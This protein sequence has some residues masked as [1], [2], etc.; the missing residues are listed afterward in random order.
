VYLGEWHTH[1][2]AD[3]TPSSIDRAD[4]KLRL[5][6]DR[7]DADFVFFLIVGLE[8][9]AVWEGSRSSHEIVRLA[10]RHAASIQAT[11]GADSCPK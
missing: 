4:W 8:E 6:R 1:P 11:Q 9:V 3:P 2:E 10:P 7:I 5:A